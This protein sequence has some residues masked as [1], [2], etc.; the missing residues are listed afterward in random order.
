MGGGHD[1]LRPG[2]RQIAD[3]S[4]SD[5][6]NGAGLCR[7]G[8]NAHPHPD[9]RGVP[10]VVVQSALRGERGLN[11][12]A[13]RLERVRKRVAYDLEDMAVVRGYRFM[14]NGMMLCE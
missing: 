3:V 14:Q 2:R 9:R 11:G 5:G 12:I 13:G 8:V 1:P 6:S 10:R 4:P 7:A